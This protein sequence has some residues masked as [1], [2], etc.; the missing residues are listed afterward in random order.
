MAGINFTD[1]SHNISQI[2][3]DDGYYHIYRNKNIIEN[4]QT[5]LSGNIEYIDISIDNP[6]DVNANPENLSVMYWTVLH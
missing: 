6:N 2:L 5:D 3:R 4:I 1:N